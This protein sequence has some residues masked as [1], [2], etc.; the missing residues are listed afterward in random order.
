MTYRFNIPEIL[1]WV[2]RTWAPVAAQADAAA[3]SRS[4]FRHSFARNFG[5]NPGVLRR[6]PQLEAGA[7]LAANAER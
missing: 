7:H 6:R 1:N 4:Y 5:E 2:V 3:F